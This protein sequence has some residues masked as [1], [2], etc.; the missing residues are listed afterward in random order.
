EHAGTFRSSIAAFDSLRLGGDVDRALAD[1]RNPLETYIGTAED[2][3]RLAFQNPGQAEARYP[4][5]QAAFEQLEGKMEAFGDATV[6]HSDQASAAGRSAQARL[7][8]LIVGVLILGAGLVLGAGALVSNAIVRDVGE[9]QRV[10]ALVGAGDLTA[11]AT[12]ASRNELGEVSDA[13]NEAVVGM[14]TALQAERVDWAEVG[15]QRDEVNRVRQMVENAPINIVYADRDFV[16]RYVNRSAVALF[17]SLEQYLPIRA[18]QL[19]GQSIDIFHRNPAHQRKLLGEPKNLPHTAKIKIGPEDVELR[20][21]AIMDDKGGYIGPMLTWDVV[22]AK[23]RTEAQIKEAQDREAEAGVALRRKVD[24]ILTVVN[25][26][27]E[28]D[29]TRNVAVRGDDAIGQLGAGLARFFDDLGRSLGEIRQ[30]GGQL[31]G[32]SGEMT[33]TSQTMSS[34]AEETAAQ[35]SVV[36][37]AADEVSKNVQTVATGTE[38]MMESIREISK[39]ANEAAKVASQ[40]VHVV[41]STDVTVNKL[42]TSSAE[43]G[44][45]I[46]VITAIA[47]QTNLLALNA[48]I[49]AAR[50]GEAGKGFA[51]VANEV[52]ELAKET[53]KA[54][55]DISQR[56][57]AIQGDT[58]NAVGAIREIRSI[59][60]RISEIQVS[61]ASAVEEQTATTTEMGRS[62]GEAARGAA[63]IA[64]N[65][66]G[67]AEA[68][69]ETTRGATD[70]LRAGE[71]V[72]RL[73]GQLDAQVNRFKIDA[74][75]A[76]VAPA[77]TTKPKKAASNGR[78]ALAGTRR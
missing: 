50:A 8:L 38:Q 78:P 39:N 1:L 73:A 42:G 18:D 19:V 66:T 11:V 37:S 31:K 58:S 33:H 12:V 22:T 21:A 69:Q 29:L 32:S 57:E 45:V 48:T 36:S 2:L 43:I 27:A 71:M 55:E 4:E 59:V 51:V 23:L 68:A 75:D 65:I 61:I 47:Q 28:G 62:L 34:A 20:I 70:A 72:A 16:I 64:Q 10:A 54:T 15:R 67:V 77:E 13:L 5:F 3:T 30:A 35:A 7:A 40:A 74:A 56:I 26:A 25:A 46:K 24:E 17:R 53:A 9:V 52:K 41:E 6:A 44:E 76:T 60:Q 63:E 49:E 14:R